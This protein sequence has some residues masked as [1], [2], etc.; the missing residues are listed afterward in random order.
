MLEELSESLINIIQDT[1]QPLPYLL[2]IM[3]IPWTCFFITKCSSNRL[4]LLGI[5]PRRL[6]GLPG[7][8]LCPLLHADFNHLFFNSIPLL[9]LSDF[10]LMNGLHYFFIS[11]L[12]ITLLSGVFVWL[13]GKPGLHVGASGLITG[14]WALLVCNSYLTTSVTSII[15]ALLSVYYFS[16]IFF[17]ILPLKRGVSWEGHLFGLLAGVAT[18]ALLK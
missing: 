8:V 1:R 5:I 18:S 17:G 16:G 6:V 12:I 2:W 13:F 3:V 10:L 15:L 7:I 14:Y 4:L 11:T 9:V